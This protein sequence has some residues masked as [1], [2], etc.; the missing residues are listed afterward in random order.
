MYTYTDQV[1][2]LSGPC[3]FLLPPQEPGGEDR[4]AGLG[5]GLWKKAQANLIKQ[6]LTRLNSSSCGPLIDGEDQSNSSS[7]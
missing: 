3:R 1:S 5:K 6:S 2:V 7:K 4:E